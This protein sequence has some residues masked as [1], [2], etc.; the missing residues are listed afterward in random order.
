MSN[1]ITLAVIRQH[2]RERG[3]VVNDPFITDS[4]LN[5]M[6]NASY[7]SL[8]NLQVS[9]NQDYFVNESSMA[10]SSGV[11]SYPLP[12][13]FHKC[14]GDDVLADGTKYIPLKKFVFAERNRHGIMRYTIQA[15]NL[16]LR[17][18]PNGDYTLKLYYVPIYTQLTTDSSTLD[19]VNGYEEYIVWDC[20]VK[21]RQKKEEDPSIALSERERIRGE[22]MEAAAERD[23]SAP[24]YVSNANSEWD[25]YCE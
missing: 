8:Y 17:P 3:D 6:I 24:A 22:I 25:D 4:E 12:T 13:D 18:I 5:T 10:V 7:A 19:G 15:N 16:K 20:V 1:S 9:L 23:S 2:I 14:L 11:D 21:C